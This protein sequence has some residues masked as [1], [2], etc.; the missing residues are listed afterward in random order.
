MGGYGGGI[1]GYGRGICGGGMGGYGGG[2]E[3]GKLVVKSLDLL[4][5]LVFHLLDLR[6][7]LNMD[8]PQ[9]A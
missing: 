8:R 7:D 4:L 2:I 1:G 3:G 9:E 6:I 5:L